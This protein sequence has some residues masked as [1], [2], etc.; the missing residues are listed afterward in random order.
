M[1]R[2]MLG[3][4]EP[5][6]LSQLSKMIR[7]LFANA[8]DRGR[9]GRAAVASAAAIVVIASVV[10]IIFV[11][12]DVVVAA[13][14]VTCCCCC[15]CCCSVPLLDQYILWCHCIMMSLYHGIVSLYHGIIVLCYHC[16][17]PGPVTSAGLML[18]DVSTDHFRFRGEV[19]GA[20]EALTGG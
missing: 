7:T 18:D 16:I 3:G 4:S 2:T 14:I 9:G 10:V 11:V 5:H 12:V 8:A 13:A 19:P 6:S 15:C 1:N 17:S 20:L